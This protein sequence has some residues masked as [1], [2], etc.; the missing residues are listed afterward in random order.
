MFS[1]IIETTE[2]I[3]KSNPQN[4][5]FQIWIQKPSFFDDI[6]IGDSI[7]T[8]GVCLTVEEYTPEFLK[9]TLG[10]ETLKILGDSF[11]NH[12]L[13]SKK[14]NLERTLRYGDRVH[15]HMV[16]GHV[17]TT[18]SILRSEALGDNWMMTVQI[19]D[20]YLKFCWKKGSV[21][22]NGVSLTINSIDKN[23]LEVC[24]IPETQKRTNLPSFRAGEK[25]TFEADSFAKAIVHA[26][27]RRTDS[28]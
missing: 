8:N 9:F 7:S 6:K 10:S 4:S 15:G 21:A 20:E 18:V 5:T 19:P 23:E 14:L 11:L 12:W 26:I 13:S 25:L 28:D 1:G 24:L 17:D 27:E 2:S 3:I 16:S 22:L